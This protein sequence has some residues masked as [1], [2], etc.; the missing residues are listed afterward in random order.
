MT[1]L[2]VT[3]IAE[4]GAPDRTD[5]A[6]RRADPCEGQAEFS[7]SGE[8]AEKVS[9]VS[10][11]GQEHLGQSGAMGCLLRFG[12]T[13]HRGDWHTYLVR[14]VELTRPDAWWCLD[15]DVIE[16][17]GRPRPGRRTFHIAGLREV[18]DVYA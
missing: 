7:R 2:I 15:A 13:N 10:A 5:K 18:E 11:S 3:A 6:G 16:R 9:A 14:P 12:Y 4:R 8:A 17:D 1:M